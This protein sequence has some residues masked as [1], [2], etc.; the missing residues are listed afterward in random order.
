MKRLALIPLFVL[1]SQAARADPP[2]TFNARLNFY[3]DNTEF[4]NRF[5]EGQTLLGVWGRLFFDVDLNEHV[6]VRGGVFGNQRFG[7]SSALEMVRPVFALVLRSRTSRFI[8]GTLETLETSD[9]FG[10]DR[11]TLHGLLPLMQVETLS[12]TRPYE[13]GFQWTV[14]GSRLRQQA[15][16]NWQRLNTPTGRELLDSG[17]VGRLALKP[18]V[19]L[20]Y[21]WHIVHH[22]GQQFHSGPVSDSFTGGPGLVIEPHVKGL[23]RASAE[24]YGFLSRD[25]RDRERASS[26]LNGLG[27][28][29]RLAGERAGWRGHLIVWRACDFLKEEGDPNYGV[30]QR[31]G[32]RFRATRDYAEVGLTRAF[33]PAPEVRVEASARAYRVEGEYDYSYRVL[34]KANLKFGVR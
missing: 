26:A 18:R 29:A 7:S 12:F 30:R 27:V 4:T 2:V 22:G 31:D 5:R 32:T 9:G 11:A 21:Q 1:F 24:V 17:V 13:N 6:T 3:G 33:Q 25:V 19:A 14:T 23:D 8:F 34:A 20:G 16:I 15:W 28:F 10:P